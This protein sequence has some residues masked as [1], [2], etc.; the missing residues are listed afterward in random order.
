MGPDRARVRV[1]VLCSGELPGGRVSLGIEVAGVGHRGLRGKGFHELQAMLASL[2]TR[3]EAELSR[4]WGQTV[5]AGPGWRLR[6]KMQDGQA[7]DH[8]R[9]LD[10]GPRCPRAWSGAASGHASPR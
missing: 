1:C 6:A 8:N 4:G 3:E 7:S 9:C 5:T 2:C 10:H